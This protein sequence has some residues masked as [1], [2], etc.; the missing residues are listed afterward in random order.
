[1]AKKKSLLF[2]AVLSS[3]PKAAQ[4]HLA[5]ATKQWHTQHGQAFPRLARKQFDPQFYPVPVVS[6]EVTSKQSATNVCC[7]MEKDLPKGLEDDQAINLKSLYISIQR[8]MKVVVH[9]QS[10]HSNY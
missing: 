2:H 9:A 7:R 4:A 5:A 10:G 3:K 8:R 6:N 1:M